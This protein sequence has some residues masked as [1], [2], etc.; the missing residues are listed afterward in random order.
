M[1][2]PKELTTVTTLSKTM[3]FITFIVLPILAFMA[4]REYQMMK[5]SPISL[6][7]EVVNVSKT[8]NKKFAL[9][10]S[11]DYHTYTDPTNAFT[12][13]YPNNFKV[14]GGIYEPEGKDELLIGVYQRAAGGGWYG[15]FNISTE[16]TSGFDTLLKDVYQTN[17]N[18]TWTYPTFTPKYT[19]IA[20]SIIDGITAHNY[21]E[22][23]QTMGDRPIDNSKLTIIKVNSKYYLFNYG[24]QNRENIPTTEPEYGI[25]FPQVFNEIISS[26]QFK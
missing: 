12:F 26:F 9:E 3:A 19:R 14:E 11:K 8:V 22:I 23:G 1:A 20:D 10:V 25:D 2:L 18:E 7:N 4:G 21:I 13:E 16:G 5:T 6:P 24:Y 17:I 15:F